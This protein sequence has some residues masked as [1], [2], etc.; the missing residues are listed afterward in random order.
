MKQRLGSQKGQQAEKS[1]DRK[2]FAKA[3]WQFPFLADTNI[4]KQKP[5]SK[6]MLNNS[7]FSEYNCASSTHMSY[8][9]D[10]VY[11]LEPNG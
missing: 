1:L 5:V 8:L 11:I 4:Y 6:C 9:T 10:K 3:L 2:K 7:F